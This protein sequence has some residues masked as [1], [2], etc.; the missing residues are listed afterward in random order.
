VSVTPTFSTYSTVACTFL[1]HLHVDGVSKGICIAKS[2]HRPRGWPPR[3]A[4]SF[5][6]PV[7]SE[8]SLFSEIDA[9]GSD[10]HMRSISPGQSGTKGNDTRTS[11]VSTDRDNLHRDNP[12]EQGAIFIPSIIVCLKSMHHVKKFYK[13]NTDKAIIPSR[14]MGLRFREV[15]ILRDKKGRHR[16]RSDVTIQKQRMTHRL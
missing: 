4:L 12:R 6:L 8:M 15:C 14:T 5:L 3:Y 13:S 7:T 2:W 1:Y 16:H 10:T 9:E 11:A